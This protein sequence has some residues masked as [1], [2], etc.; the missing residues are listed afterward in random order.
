MPLD[1]VKS[2]GKV[3]EKCG[4]SAQK[5]CKESGIGSRAGSRGDSGLQEESGVGTRDSGTG[6]G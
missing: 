1:A 6:L 2:V 3:W 4:K 5:V